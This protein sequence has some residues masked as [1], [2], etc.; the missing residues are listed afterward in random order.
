MRLTSKNW[1]SFLLLLLHF[2]ALIVLCVMVLPLHADRMFS[3]LD[4]S[5]MRYLT[6][7]Q[8]QG[9]NYFTYGMNILE[10]LGDMSFPLLINLIPSSW[11]DLFLQPGLPYSI[12]TYTALSLQYFFAAFLLCRVFQFS[13]NISL[14]TS[15]LITLF[16]LPLLPTHNGWQPFYQITPISPYLIN[17]LFF[18]CLLVY[19]FFYIGCTRLVPT[20]LLSCAAFAITL[21][22]LL[23][24]AVGFFIVVPFFSFFCCAFILTAKSKFEFFSKITFSIVTI[25][26]LFFLNYFQFL[27]GLLLYSVPF[28]FPEKLAT[29][30]TLSDISILLNTFYPAGIYIAGLG[31]AGMAATLF[32]GHGEL[33]KF[34]ILI[35][36]YVLIF[37]FFGSS[38]VIF[39]GWYHGP[40]P[41]YFEYMLWPL[42]MAFAVML[43]QYSLN[44]LKW[45][46]QSALKFFTHQ[47]PH[48]F[49]QKNNRSLTRPNKTPY[50][51][52]IF[53]ATI[54]IINIACASNEPKEIFSYPQTN[55]PPI[56]QHLIKNSAIDQ[57]GLFKGYTE[58]FYPKV[59]PQQP[60]DWYRQMGFDSQILVSKVGYPYRMVGLW[61][62]NIPTINKYSPI[63]SPA[64]FSLIQNTLSRP[65][66]H[67]IRNI[68]LFTKINIPLLQALGVHHIITNEEIKFPNTRLVV[69]EAINSE[70]GSFYLYEIL[71]TN[72][73][74]YS[75]KKFRILKNLNIFLDQ[76]DRQRID[77]NSVAY[78]TSHIPHKIAKLQN[79]KLYQ[80]RNG[81]RLI[82][83]A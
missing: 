72:I 41:L 42:Y 78:V 52:F 56:I 60:S 8:H 31:L 66:D 54:V 44:L 37:I 26:A 11:F 48:Q 75:P 51:V 69:T 53:T 30:F 10:G 23:V 47:Q 77:F 34:T 32:F 20:I 12:V 35:F 19:C 63:I 43:L 27:F 16:V 82:A 1:D 49:H 24:N 74:N 33:K 14:S 59:K 7:Q 22:L 70:H 4:G 38:V 81:V 17:F 39:P 80:I 79:A 9:M 3:W 28:F 40:N 76:I 64:L 25:A 21:Y 73:A 67:N 71:H 83:N 65:I 46:I 36:S 18:C 57:S 61:F 68:F 15:W 62:F 58:S 6:I 2:F 13:K 45:V 55:P 5:F 50:F 29:H